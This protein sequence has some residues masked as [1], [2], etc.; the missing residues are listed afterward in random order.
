MWREN[1]KLRKVRKIGQ[2]LNGK[3]SRIK[4]LFNVVRAV[5]ILYK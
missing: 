1:T 4:I 5:I 3:M 2:N